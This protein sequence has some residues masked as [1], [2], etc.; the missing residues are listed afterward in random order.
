MPSG[1]AILSGELSLSEGEII[2]IIITNNSPILGRAISIN[3]FNSTISFS[4]ASSS[5]VVNL[6]TG[7]IDWCLWVTSSVYYIL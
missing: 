4:N 5:L 2:V 3:I 1:E 6:V 7:T